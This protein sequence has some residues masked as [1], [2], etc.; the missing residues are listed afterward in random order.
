MPGHRSHYTAFWVKD[1]VLSIKRSCHLM[2]LSRAAYCRDENKLAVQDASVI[3]A[4][5]AIVAKHG[6][7]GFWKICRRMAA[8]QSVLKKTGSSSKK[9]GS[10]YLFSASR[11]SSEALRRLG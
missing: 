2:D 4:L 6:R 3:E 5:N 9:S 7:W 11:S 1:Q 10:H 8:G